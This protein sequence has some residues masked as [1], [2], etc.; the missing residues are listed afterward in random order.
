M[1]ALSVN[2]NEKETALVIN[3]PKPISKWKR[4]LLPGSLLGCIVT[5]M[6]IAICVYFSR[7]PKLFDVETKAMTMAGAEAGPLKPGYRT[8]KSGLGRHDQKS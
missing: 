1:N 7:S 3:E 6:L 5:L 4:Y 8:Q 2:S